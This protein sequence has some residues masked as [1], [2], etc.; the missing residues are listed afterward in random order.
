M[1]A[2]W[3][4]MIIASSAHAGT[5]RAPSPPPE[6][7]AG[8]TATHDEMVREQRALKAFNAVL[9]D[10][11]TCLL[12]E[13]SQAVIGK[14]HDEARSLQE[15]LYEPHRKLWT[16]LSWMTA[17]FN[18]ELKVFRATG[19]GSKATPADCSPY[20]AQAVAAAAAP[21]PPIPPPAVPP[22]PTPPAADAAAAGQIVVVSGSPTVPP[23]DGFQP[24]PHGSWAYRVVRS[25]QLEPCRF[26]GAPECT[27]IRIE[28][29]NRS[30][31]AIECHAKAVLD[32][33]NHEGTSSIE[34][35][36]VVGAGKARSI[37]STLMMPATTVSLS[38]ATCQEREPF[39][40]LDTPSEC[41]FQVIRPITVSDYYPATS[42]RIDEE[43]L[44][45]VQF[46]LAA[47]EGK[48]FNIRVIGSSLFDRLDAAAI[49]A[50]GD[51][52]F[53]TACPGKDFRMQLDFNLE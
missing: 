43:G 30:T 17:C 42:R 39:P 49:K 44:V 7:P 12:G 25:E 34:S 41:K 6:V 47:K 27:R 28:V 1:A 31:R 35:P 38:T 29:E 23:G 52:V 24:I 16:R 3:L 18:N 40:H 20:L 5:C 22:P 2:T 8:A 51:I 32:G 10:Y 14:T 53:S 36:G 21:D 15:A 33:G 45:A 19:G 11:R 50:V 13:G 4:L 9:D 48:A 46:T 37:L 26:R